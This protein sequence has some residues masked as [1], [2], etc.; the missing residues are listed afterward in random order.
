MNTVRILAVDDHE[1]T[2]L[3]YKYILE[4][5]DFTGFNVK[6]EIATSFE[7][8]KSKIEL[9]KRAVPYDLILLDIQL[10]SPESKD[11]RTG[12][13]LGMVA[14]AEVPNSKVVFM[15]S[16]SDNYRIN[17]IFKTVNPDGYM[18][19]SEI[20]E[21]SLKTMVETIVNESPYYTAS[22]LS[23]IRRRMSTDIVIDEQDQKILYHL[24]QGIHTRDIAPLIGSANTTVEARKR[25]LK[26]LF[27]VKNGND[28]ALIN[29]AKTRGFL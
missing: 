9:S 28:L 15:S 11:I 14:R 22:A 20:D 17:N 21:M 12:I 2:A 8:G 16:Y 27:D 23:A 25:Q 5:S 10:F 6:V 1:M 26:A 7:K 3:G 29:E 4:D 24:S 19:K 18:V 13:D